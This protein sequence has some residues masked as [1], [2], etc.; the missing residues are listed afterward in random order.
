MVTEQY[1]QRFDALPLS[2]DWRVRREAF[3]IYFAVRGLCLFCAVMPQKSGLNTRQG[4]VIGLPSSSCCSK[5]VMFW[6]IGLIHG[7]INVA[8]TGRYA[9]LPAG[10]RAQSPGLLRYSGCFRINLDFNQRV[11]RDEVVGVV[12]CQLSLVLVK[13]FKSLR[14]PAKVERDE[15]LAGYM[16][17]CGVRISD[18]T[19]DFLRAHADLQFG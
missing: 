10:R 5:P 15:S 19:H 4:K 9:G 3:Q 8:K 6:L 13:G 17:V 18:Q 1:F 12:K 2:Q 11:W 16:A 7:S 14:I